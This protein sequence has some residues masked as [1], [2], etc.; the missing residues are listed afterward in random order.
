MVLTSPAK[1]SLDLALPQARFGEVDPT[2]V[3]NAEQVYLQTS[4]VRIKT[5]AICL[6]D[7][8]ALLMALGED[9]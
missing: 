8:G 7:T 4:I 6:S 1:H 5:E 3:Y 2:T 9:W